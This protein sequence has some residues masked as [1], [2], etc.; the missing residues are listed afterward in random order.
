MTAYHKT[1]PKCGG[2]L[3]PTALHPS[4]PPHVCTACHIGWF[5]AELTDEAR[6]AYRPHLHDHGGLHEKVRKE[7]KKELEA[8]H[9][10]GTS[11]REE[12]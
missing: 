5:V 4:A 8:A 3:T 12:S 7:V 2:P 9:A 11:A 10:R 1:C 6:M